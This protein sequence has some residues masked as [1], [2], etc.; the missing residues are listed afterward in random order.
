MKFYMAPM[1]G[2]TGFIYRNAYHR[3]F[4]DVDQY[5][6]PFIGNR[7][8]SS[9]EKNDILP[10]HNAGLSVVPQILTNRAD[11]FLEIARTLQE[12]GYDTVNLNLGCPSGTVVAK[13]RGAGFLALPDELDRFLEEIFHKCP[14]RISIKTRIGV[15]NPGEWERLLAIYEQYPLEELIIHPRVQKDFYKNEPRMDAFLFAVKT[16]RHALCYN[17]DIA[18]LE[19]YRQ[20]TGNIADVKLNRV[21]LG[22]GILKNPGL[23]GEIRGQKR[24]SKTAVKKFHDDIL[25]GYLE[26]M[27]GERNTLF[28]MKELW[29]YLGQSFT[30]P[31][32]YLKKIRKTQRVSEYRTLVDALFSE[33]EWCP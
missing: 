6:T 14:L 10:V 11:D 31:E 12:Y 24:V 20:V 27:S 33:Q 23:I 18:S 16:S 17:G 9:R 32:K 2:L 30:S 13:Y 1:E 5:I 15:E 21:M 7:N 29:S 26:V 19:D 4:G 22:R 8:L 28:R 25:V 3:N